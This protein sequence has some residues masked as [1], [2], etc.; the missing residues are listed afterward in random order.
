MM[1]TAL[2]LFAL[3]CLVQF[4]AQAQDAG[5]PAVKTTVVVQ[6]KIS[7]WQPSGIVLLEGQTAKITVPKIKTAEGELVEQGWGI[8]DPANRGNCAYF[9]CANTAGESFVLP[10]AAEGALLVRNSISK[11][12]KTFTGTQREITVQGPGEIEF[13]ANDEFPGKEYYKF[14]WGGKLK[15][16]VKVSNGGGYSDNS[17]Q[18]NVDIER[19]TQDAD[20]PKMP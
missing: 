16:R 5:T 17:G 20:T 7:Q 6:A 15:V 4:A 10:G 12:I 2:V 9:G 1:K 3:T 11:E 8:I 13:I 14:V 19:T 18:A